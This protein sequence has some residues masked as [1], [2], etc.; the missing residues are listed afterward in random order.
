MNLTDNVAIVTGGGGS[1]GRAVALELARDGARIALLDIDKTQAQTV[2]D[3]VVAGGGEA[4]ALALDVRDRSAVRAAMAIVLQRFGRLDIFVSSAGG[5]A[6]QRMRLLHEL[7]DDTLDWVLGVNLVGVL[8]CLKAVL[9]PMI[10]RGRGRIVNIG[11]VVAMQ[12]KAQC[13]DYAAA[14]GGIIALTKSLAIELGERGITVN[15]C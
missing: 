11:S 9:K 12:G 15:C 5:S 10:E 7:D 4:T 14:K 1:I 8:N 3:E 2:A 13:V 6:R